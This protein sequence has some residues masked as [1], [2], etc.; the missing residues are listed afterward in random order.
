[1]GTKVS[2]I[3]PCYINTDDESD[4]EIIFDVT[5]N[6]KQILKNEVWNRKF[7]FGSNANLKE[8]KPSEIV[9]ARVKLLPR[10]VSGFVDHDRIVKYV[11]ENT[12]RLHSYF[13]VNNYKDWHYALG[14]VVIEVELNYSS[15]E[16]PS[17][18]Q[19]IDFSFDS[20]FLDTF[21]KHKALLYELATLFVAGLHLTY[22]TRSLMMWNDSPVNDGIYSTFSGRKKSISRL[23]TDMFMHHVLI[24][25]SRLDSVSKNISGLAG[26]WHLNLWSLKR[27]LVAVKSNLINMDNLLDLVYSLEGLFE[28][29]ASSDFIKLFCTLSLA[30]NKSEAHGTKNLLDLAFK[31]RNEIAHGGSY[32]NGYEELH[33]NGKKILAE[34]VYWEMKTL[35]TQMLIKAISKLINTPGMKNLT[36]K[37][38]D[39][40]ELV[41]TE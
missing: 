38:D 13:K 41:Y 24:T 21:H 12:N 20:K 34:T 6:L 37:K 31:I 40:F 18:Q 26:A 10:F 25:K 27:F 39:L 33:L 23:S 30:S 36:F 4:E 29:N 17:K 5:A 11:N 9:K 16:I 2:W 32:Y 8:I 19:H 15:T 22:P 14:V 7:E 1:M 28:K 35:V 3:T